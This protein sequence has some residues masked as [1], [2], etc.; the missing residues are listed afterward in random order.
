MTDGHEVIEDG[1]DPLNGA[2]D[3]QL[4]TLNIEFDYDKSILRPQYYKDLDVVIKVL[5]R[6]AGATARIEGHADKRPKSKRSY[7][8]KLSE[9]RAKAVMEYI[10]TAGGIDPSRLTHKGYGF[11]RPLVPNDTEENM[12]HNRR[13]EIYIRPSAEG[14]DLDTGTPFEA[15]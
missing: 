7:N 10:A 8:I 3:L 11:D 1:T 12:Q 14:E 5:Q 4:Y 13:T 9:R 2:D 6:D 15:P